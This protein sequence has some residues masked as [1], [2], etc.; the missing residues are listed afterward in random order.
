[1][2]VDDTGIPL[3]TFGGAATTPTPLKLLDENNLT[4]QKSPCS[5]EQQVDQA[6]SDFTCQYELPSNQV[7]LHELSV[8]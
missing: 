3:Y 2:D 7:V 1:M 8:E 4:F 5:A 6:V